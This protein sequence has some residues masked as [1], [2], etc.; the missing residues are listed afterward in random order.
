MV[1]RHAPSN[2]VDV[3]EPSQKAKQILEG[4]KLR[5]EECSV[6]QSDDMDVKQAKINKRSDKNRNFT[7]GPSS[8][9]PYSEAV[10][11]DELKAT[12]AS[13]GSVA[14]PMNLDNLGDNS[15]DETKSDEPLPDVNPVSSSTDSAAKEMAISREKT[16][17]DAVKPKNKRKKKKS[18]NIAAV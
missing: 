6:S 3:N 11:A 4:Q 7:G 8:W 14:V 15:R 10:N 2:A 1:K 18:S 13:R 16:L 17:E 5:S 9:D 12:L